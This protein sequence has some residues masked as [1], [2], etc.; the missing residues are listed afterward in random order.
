[1]VIASEYQ[2]RR[3][4]GLLRRGEAW[5]EGRVSGGHR[6]PDP[7]HYWVVTDPTRQE[8]YHVRVEERPR[9]GRYVV[10]RGRG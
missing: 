10:K 1:M 4:G 6:W 7:P 9:W 5:I 2:I 8:V 3:L